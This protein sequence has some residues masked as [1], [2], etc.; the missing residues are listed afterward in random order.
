MHRFGADDSGNAGPMT[1]IERGEAAN[2][3]LQQPAN[4]RA[5]V[6]RVM[7]EDGILT[8]IRIYPV[9]LGGDGRPW[10]RTD[11]PMKPEPP[12]AREILSQVQE[13]SSPF[14]TNIS[15]EDDPAYGPIGVIRVE[16]SA[17]VPVGGDVRS[18]FSSGTP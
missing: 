8:E 1:A 18:E 6:A 2:Q 13:Y 16:R 12:L 15:I 4:Q 17:T 10:S 7:Y 11:V 9:D 5:Y 3:W 14:G